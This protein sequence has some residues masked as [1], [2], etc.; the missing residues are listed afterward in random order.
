MDTNI[1]DIEQPLTGRNV[2]KPTDLRPKP[3]QD[4]DL[5]LVEPC[6]QVMA[7]A[8]PG[9]A[10]PMHPCAQL[11]HPTHGWPFRRLVKLVGERLVLTRPWVAESALR[12]CLDEQ[13]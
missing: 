7:L 10:N 6:N 4:F 9:H 11:E 3:A 12:Y 2:I 8:L 5:P 1:A 13:R